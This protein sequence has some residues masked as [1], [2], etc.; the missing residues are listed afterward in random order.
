MAK[1]Q[2]KGSMGQDP[3]VTSAQDIKQRLA[4]ELESKFKELSQEIVDLKSKE[5][6]REQVRYYADQQQQQL[7]AATEWHIRASRLEEELE[8]Q[9][10]AFY[11]ELKSTKEQYERLLENAEL[12]NQQEYTSKLH[13]E[14]ATLAADYEFKLN[15]NL[16]AK[17]QELKIKYAEDLE[18]QKLLI[19]QVQQRQNE[20]YIA[21]LDAQFT[22]RFMLK[23]KEVEIARNKIQELTA[24][25][26]N[27][28]Q[29]MKQAV[30][31]MRTQVE[32]ELGAEYEAKAQRKFLDYAQEKD[33]QVQKSV[34]EQKQIIL[35][36]V[37]EEKVIVLKYK[38]TE[39]REQNEALI[40]KIK[41]EN[42]AEN[43]RILKAALSVQEQQLQQE[44]SKLTQEFFVKRQELQAQLDTKIQEA[45][46]QER[47]NLTQQ[48]N[49]EKK[50]L[51]QQQQKVLLEQ[52]KS[53]LEAKLAA[54]EKKILDSNFVPESLV[55]DFE[56][57]LAKKQQE[58]TEVLNREK[59]LALSRQEKTLRDCFAVE[60]KTHLHK[61]K[62]EWEYTTAR[63]YKN[64][65]QGLLSEHE[66][67]IREEFQQILQEQRKQDAAQFTMQKEQFLREAIARYEAESLQQLEDQLKEQNANKLQEAVDKRVALL[68]QEYER[69]LANLDA[70][71]KEKY[72]QR[73]DQERKQLNLKYTKDKAALQQDL[74]AKFEQEKQQAVAE[75]ETELRDS[76]YREMVKQKDHMQAKYASSQE[77][78]LQEL[79]RRLEAQHKQEI[80]RIKQG[81][82]STKHPAEFSKTVVNTARTQVPAAERGVEQLAERILAKFQVN[83]ED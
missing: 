59:D 17:E 7:V 54:Q 42:D 34:E 22:T 58:I 56:Q 19:Q 74:A 14:A 21:E 37:E 57:K 3:F 80:E 83:R 53:D 24:E 48:H 46:L 41:T 9:K 35:Q 43:Q 44:H 61:A 16:L 47:A 49:N 23:E 27:L 81:Y 40:A 25:L 18:Q 28:S 75:F 26:E 50:M 65:E 52:Y 67:K 32:A 68:E 15:K 11:S 31:R 4:K 13:K 72:E 77:L 1:S 66:K 63:E 51:L 8:Q 33:A 6:E 36:K 5:Q 30:D 78:A 70:K 29:Q 38:E 39:L 2:I 45:V 62:S 76:L 10:L 64:K 55:A 20:A 79:R 60:L 69:K 73:I 71:Q 82:F 12:R